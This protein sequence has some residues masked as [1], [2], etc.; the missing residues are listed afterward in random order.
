MKTI[1]KS[2][3]SK[4]LV[5][6]FMI[7]AF[8]ISAATG[9]IKPGGEHRERRHD[10]RSEQV[11]QAKEIS[12]AGFSAENF[13]NITENASVRSEKTNENIHIYFGLFW[14]A[15][16]LFHVIQHWNWFKK[17]FSIEHVMKNKLLTVTMIVFV[18]MAISGII[19]WTEVLPRG[20]FNF[21]E[22]HE[23]TGQ[24][25][26]GLMLIHVFQRVKWYFSVPAKIF[27]RKTILA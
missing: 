6:V 24:L 9:L 12:T 19:I 16:M 5:N 20:F 25:L 8:G 1:I 7:A 18:L 14:L 17:M 4:Y 26:L 23:V 27:K 13:K 22:I 10:F 15:L 2:L 3:A 21:K 11:T